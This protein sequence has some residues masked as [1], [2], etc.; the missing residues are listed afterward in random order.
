VQEL[1]GR[2]VQKRDIG[3]EIPGLKR[4]ESLYVYAE[5]TS[6][7]LDPL[8]VLLKPGL[9]IETVR[10][11]LA[12]VKQ[13]A[14]HGR[15]PLSS[16]REVLDDSSL[17]WSDDFKGKHEAA[18]ELAVP[19]DGD[20]QLLLMGTPAHE[21]FGDYRLFIGI[22]AP[23]VLEGEASER[24]ETLARLSD[25]IPQYSRAVEEVR[26]VLSAHNPFR[27]Y[28]LKD[29]D[30][31]DTL[32][33]YIEATSGKLKPVVTLYDFGDKPL[34]HANFAGTEGHAS[35]KY[36]F[37]HDALNYR[38]RVSGKGPDAK[39]IPTGDFRLLVGVN[40]PE[41][42]KGNA[43]STQQ[44]VLK[45]PMPV[46]IGI[47]LEQI[48]DVDQKAENYTAVVFLTLQWQ[49]PNLAF[50]TTSEQRIKFF[51]GDG[52]GRALS[53]SGT[54]W[55]EF[56][57]FNQQGRRAVK[58]R[59]VGVFP[60]G[61]VLYGEHF[62][63]TL[64]APDFDFRLYPF[65]SQR[66]FIR[67]DLLLP[68]W[69]YVFEELE[70]FSGIGDRL[71]EEEWVIS[72]VNT[73]LG[74][75]TIV[76]RPT[77]SFSLSFEAHR[78]LNYYV[79]RIFL[80]ILIIITI[81]WLIFFLRDYGKRVDAASANLLLFIAFNFTISNDLPRLGYLTFLDMVLVSTFSVTGLVLVLAVFLR[82][83]VDDGREAMV[84]R[85]DRYVISLYPVAYC[86]AL[87][88]V[89]VLLFG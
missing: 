76:Q 6:G 41:V 28:N 81:S 33:V 3:Y 29:S 57:L 24:T 43:A 22:D 42:L 23:E 46:K 18:F 63:V 79:L 78:H 89:V 69:I 58:D 10:Q 72:E 66:F 34:A 19:A 56:L 35:L 14:S 48:T 26:G 59:A 40:T 82:R 9:D 62:T 65:D 49:D 45:R 52:F 8:I 77:S 39:T 47:K 50:R 60:D 71:G 37:S 15:D 83:M 1:S 12:A 32:Y 54:F 85:I 51:A 17:V 27:F 16:V 13:T 61:S 84:K 4:G 80:P 53:G 44:T 36:T 86:I 7:N 11:S 64:Q 38:I 55:P 73:H 67:V 31:G 20:Y 25:A 70:S 2:I 21:T 5:G 68:E 30:A 87:G 88:V 74:E 75:A